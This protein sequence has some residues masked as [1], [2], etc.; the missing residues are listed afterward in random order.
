MAALLLS[1]N[2][3]TPRQCDEI[4]DFL[5]D[6]Q[7]H[8]LWAHTLDRYLNPQPTNDKEQRSANPM[9][10]QGCF[11][12]DNTPLMEGGKNNGS[13]WRRV[14]FRV[15]AAVASVVLAFGGY[16]VYACSNGESPRSAQ[17]TAAPLVKPPIDSAKVMALSE[18]FDAI[19]RTHSVRIIGR[20]KIDMDR[21][22]NF[23]LDPEANLATVMSALEFVH[24]GF[25]YAV[26]YKTVALRKR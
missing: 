1:D 13:R 9:A 20:D 3:L 6:E 12:F 5:D 26:N 21:R 7:N 25:G 11:E 15:A 24:G 16:L 8:L 18:I 2:E 23:A 17:E 10:A 22:L 19:E 4:F 14:A